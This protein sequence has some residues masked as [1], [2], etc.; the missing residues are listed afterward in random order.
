MI[1]LRPLEASDR[2]LFGPFF[3]RLSPESLYRR[4]LHPV[5]RPDQVPLDR[6]LEIDHRDREA[7]VAVEAGEL[8]GVARYARRPESDVAEL[9]LIV[10]DAWQRR[11]LG[12]RLL[13]ALADLA[14]A[15]GI[16]RFHL[17]MQADNRPALALLRRFAPGARLELSHGVF[18]ATVAL[19]EWRPDMK[20][21]QRLTALRSLPELA[22]YGDR[23]L[24]T[25]LPYLD[26][27]EVKA[28]TVLAREGEPCG[29]YVV[30]LAGEL[31]GAHRSSGWQAMW[32]RLDSCSTVTASQDSRVLVM[33]RAG[34]RAV[35][36]LG[37]RQV[38]V[39]VDDH[40][41]RGRPALRV[42]DGAL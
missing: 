33:G 41:V 35:T 26:E 11:G 16:G 8:I 12:S 9:A 37:R 31:Q 5:V 29:Q 13:A 38:G 18:E 10:A 17:S 4:F 23:E 19:K 32:D 24:R 39:V 22:P 7:V 27:V 30:L 1:E 34:F 20:H 2:D 40:G 42:G 25:L 36:A 3:E 6:L 21:D 15:A 14:N 28:G